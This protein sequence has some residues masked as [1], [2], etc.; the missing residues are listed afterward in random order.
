MLS[1]NAGIKIEW[2]MENPAAERGALAFK[3]LTWRV[4]EG[5]IAFGVMLTTPIKPA[6]RF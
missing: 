6:W 2:R 3:M 4:W 1:C 5:D